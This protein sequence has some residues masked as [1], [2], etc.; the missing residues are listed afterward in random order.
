[1]LP[2][3]NVIILDTSCLILLS[4]INEL[5][6]LKQLSGKVY[7]TSIIQKEYRKGIPAWIEI[8]DPSDNHYQTILE[9]DLDKG[10]ASSIAL[11][12][13]IENGILIIDDLKGRKV[14]EK[15]SL[16]YSGTFGMI[17]KAKELGIIKSVKPILEKVRLTDFRFTEDLFQTMLKEAGE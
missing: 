12:L 10:E 11:S 17:L 15:L 6:L 16:K 2:G 4:K 1:M 13:E 14:A 3:S 5:D 8:V 7:I 9:M